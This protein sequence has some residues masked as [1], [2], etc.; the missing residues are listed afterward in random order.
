MPAKAVSL[1][2]MRERVQILAPIDGR[3]VIGGL[4]RSWNTIATVWAR[5]EEM[6]ASEQYH[7]EQVQ[8]S[9]QFAV[10]IRFRADV[11]TNQRIV[12][13]GRRF[14]ISGRPNPDER[15]RFI[16]LTCKELFT[17]A[18][19]GIDATPYLLDDD[20]VLL[21]DDDGTTSLTDEA[22]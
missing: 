18:A 17:D 10:T 7:R 16:R 5:V 11:T 9:A 13:R 15:R 20:S 4:V 8:T 2:D 12:W 19:A 6:S 14:E 1:G 3:D 21:F 22:A